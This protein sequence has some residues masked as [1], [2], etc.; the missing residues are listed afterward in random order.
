MKVQPPKFAWKFFRWF[1][2]K[3]Y[4]EEIEGDL[5][6]LFEKQYETTPSLARRRF[7]WSVIR[8]FR[9]GFIRSFSPIN[10]NTTTMFKNNIK[11]A[12]RNLKRQPFFAFLNTFGLAIGMAGTL[13]I[14]LFIHDE[15]RYDRMF[16]D[17]DRIY[18]VNISN[19]L[20]GETS[21]YASVS[22]PLADVMRQD[23]PQAQLITR[24]KE[25]NSIL[26]RKDDSQKNV[27]EEHVVGVDENFFE[28][29]GIRLLQGNEANALKEPK[30]LVLTPSAAEKHF[31][32][33]D[34]VGKSLIMDNGE[35]YLVTGIVEEMPKSSFLKDYSVFISLSSYEDA[36]SIAWNNWSYPTFVKLVPGTDPETLQTFLSGVKDNYLIPWAMTFI[37]GLTVESSRENEK[38]TGNFM[39][40]GAIALTDIH[41]HSPNIEGEFNA[42]SDIQ[43]VYIL[44]FIGLFLLVLASVNFMNLSTAR[45]LKRAKEVGLRKTLGS[46]RAGLVKQFLTEAGLISFISLAL[47]I[48]VATMIL[49]YF[50]ALSGKS[51]VMPFSNPVFWLTLLLITLVLG[52]VSGSYPAFLMSKFAPHNALKTGG[53][54]SLKG[55]KV[56]NLLVVVQFA[57]SIFLIASTLVVFQQLNFIQ[58]KDLGFKK[59]QVLIIDD[60]DAAG[61]ALESFKTEVERLSQVESVSLSSFLPTPSARNGI[62]YFVENAMDTEN[63]IIIGSWRVDHDYISTLGLELIAGRDFSPQLKTDSSSLIINESTL[64]MLG[65]TAEEAIGTRMTDDFR[66]EDKE[67]AHFMTVIGVVKNFHFESLRNGIDALSLTLDKGANKAIIKL[68]PGDFS[69]SIAQ[70]EGLWD[71]AAPGQLFNYYFMDDSFN[72]TYEAEQRLGL[73]FIT[74]TVLS[75]FIACLGLFGLA[76]FNAEKRSKEI[77]IRK[78]LGASVGQITY[79]LSIDFL[80]LVGFAIIVSIPLAWY[81]M[82]Q[83]LQDF[84]YRIEISWW[85]FALSALAAIAISILTVSQQSIR[86]AL[87]N[88]VK[89]LKVE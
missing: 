87:S 9:P 89:S 2:R 75:L 38:E 61:D 51:I 32:D 21:D 19:R 35:T 69:G 81:A 45:S 5:V 4:L 43:N 1:C 29:F 64:Q 53:G 65:L 70:I 18:R 44:S 56:R 78:V 50:N 72:Q 3:D 84:S 82:N 30:S 39:R 28:M 20:A 27:K 6:E 88:P 17:A 31:P 73:I 46:S 37:P 66:R 36:K 63:A 48:G 55:G 67:N 86:A 57:V 76:A 79:K 58:N 34:I 54:S 16:S 25:S 22:G 24:F 47:A 85:I 40:F 42:N 80:R 11:I 13:L 52:L 7:I 74:F 59:D 23:F 60:A 62:T 26:L 15:L 41:L 10:S 77:G 33:G 14:S 71:E 12:W 83:W 49:P 68:N 8:Y